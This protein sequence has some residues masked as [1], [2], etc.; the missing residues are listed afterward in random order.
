MAHQQPLQY[1]SMRTDMIGCLEIL[2][3]ADT[4]RKAWIDHDPSSGLLQH[5]WL[6]CHIFNQLDDDA[7]LD[8][9]A[10]MLGVTLTSQIE[11]AYVQ[12]LNKYLEAISC[13]GTDTETVTSPAWAAMLPAARDLLDELTRSD[14]DGR[15][16]A[17]PE[18]AE[19]SSD[20]LPD[21]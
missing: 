20:S 7:C 12:R 14:S 1:P 18:A 4:V 15:S 6:P 10:S 17:T 2:L 8:D 11:V 19:R 9:P 16:A 5:G 3:D 21:S 13:D